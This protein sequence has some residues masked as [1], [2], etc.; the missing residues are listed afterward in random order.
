[1]LANTDIWHKNC[2]YYS[3]F[4]LSLKLLKK[5]GIVKKFVKPLILV[6]LLSLLTMAIIIPGNLKANYPSGLYPG[7]FA[8]GSKWGYVCACPSFPPQCAC[9]MR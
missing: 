3:G 1:M 6:I 8:G 5:E 9:F 2:I 7:E 4:I